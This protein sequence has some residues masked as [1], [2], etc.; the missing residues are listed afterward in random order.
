MQQV[1]FDFLWNVSS[2]DPVGG[3]GAECHIIDI[4]GCRC[5]MMR[6]ILYCRLQFPFLYAPENANGI[7]FNLLGMHCFTLYWIRRLPLSLLVSFISLVSFSLHSK[8]ILLHLLAFLNI[9]SW[10][11]SLHLLKAYLFVLVWI[12]RDINIWKYISWRNKG[13]INWVLKAILI[14]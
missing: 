3:R 1:I 13:K 5:E 6:V 9:I 4:S 8:A 12:S 11:Y 2:F 10:M 7:M 14:H